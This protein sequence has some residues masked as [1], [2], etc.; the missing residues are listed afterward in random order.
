ME[1]TDLKSIWDKVVEEDKTTYTL[2]EQDIKKMI[3]KKSNVL[4]SQ[5]TRE[6]KMKRWFMG[7][8]GITSVLLSSVYLLDT[9]D[10]YLFDNVFSRVEM[11]L[12]TLFMGLLIVILFI[13]I[14][15]SYR[16][17]SMFQSSSSDL[18]TALSTSKK[19]L[20]RIQKLA[21][22][23]DSFALPLVIGWYT[24]RKLFGEG[25]FVWDIRIFYVFLAATITLILIFL[26]SRSMQRRK[27]GKYISRL[28]AHIDDMQVLDEKNIS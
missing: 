27:F 24:Y 2:D 1:L 10:S 25:A 8:V 12:L 4:F 13:N 28:Q 6:L 7:I 19:L 11:S 5:I 22:F 3:A 17:M 20:E 23:S 15:R 21:V 18:K 14:V 9:D 16:Q 26:I